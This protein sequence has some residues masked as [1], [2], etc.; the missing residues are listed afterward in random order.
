MVWPIGD[1]NSKVYDTIFC[2]LFKERL[3]LRWCVQGLSALAHEQNQACHHMLQYTEHTTNAT[4]LLICCWCDC[5]CTAIAVAIVFAVAL[6]V[7]LASVIAIA[8]GI[9]SVI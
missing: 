2:C 9:A 7:A 1:S 4:V 3:H 5:Y 8:S 6:A